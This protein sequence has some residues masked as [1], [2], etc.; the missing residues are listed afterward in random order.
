MGLKKQ[1]ELENGIMLNYHRINSINKITNNITIIEVSSYINEKQRQRE[2]EIIKQSIET[3]EA[4]PM[5]VFIETFYVNKEYLE[6]ESIQ[7]LYEYLKTTEK[8]KDAENA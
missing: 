1:I 8:F 5:N 7:D 4:V 3:G 2:Q 6:D